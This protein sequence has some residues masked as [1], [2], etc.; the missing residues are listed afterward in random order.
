MQLGFSPCK[1]FRTG[2]YC[3][4]WAITSIIFW[5]SSK[6]HIRS[7]NLINCWYSVFNTAS[8]H[9]PRSLW[10]PSCFVF[11]LGIYTLSHNNFHCENKPW[12]KSGLML[13]FVLLFCPKSSFPW[14]SREADDMMK[15]DEKLKILGGH[16][17]TSW[18]YLFKFW[19][20]SLIRLVESTTIHFSLLVENDIW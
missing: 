13:L 3:W 7:Q 14:S 4:M 15:W 11:H 16:L 19:W 10:T 17:C 20:S 8:K 9:S 12:L 6:V 1:T 5:K 2:C 18:A